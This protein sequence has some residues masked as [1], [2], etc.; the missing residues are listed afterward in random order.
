M[1][2]AGIEPSKY[3]PTIAAM[4]AGVTQVE[5]RQPSPYIIRLFAAARFGGDSP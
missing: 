1:Y 2:A 3:E 5:A 4:N